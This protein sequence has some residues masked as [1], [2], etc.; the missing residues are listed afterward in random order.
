MTVKDN[1]LAIIVKCWPRLSETFV[2]QELAALQD[3]GIRYDIWSLRHPTNDKKHPLHEKVS[4]RI[5]YLPEYLHHEPLRVIRSWLS[6]RKQPGYLDARSVWWNDLKRD[7]TRNRIRRFGQALVMAAESG[8]ETRALYSHFLHTPSSV[9][10]YCAIIRDIDWGFSAHAKDIWTSPDWEIREKLDPDQYGATFGVTCTA[11]GMQQLQKLARSPDKINLAYH[12]LDL[13]RFPSP[14]NRETKSSEQTIEL[15]SVGRL[16]EKKGFDCLLRA[17]ALLPDNLQWRWTHIGGG[18]LQDSL[19]LLA[20]ELAIDKHIDWLG[21]CEQPEVIQNMRKADIFILPSRIAADG[22]RDGLP[23]VL[24]EAAS[25]KLPLVTTSISSIPEFI[26]QGV[27]GLLADDDTPETLAGLI[28]N[29]V[30]DADLRTRMAD[31][32][33]DRLIKEFDSDRGMDCVEHHLKH[34]LENQAS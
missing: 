27:H 8:Q 31:A 25:Q 24:M 7:F 13:S 10:R 32:A 20:Q 14:P 4:A 17:L 33:Y 23:N 9:T 5:H 22:D 2:A 11:V 21:E 29:L 16:V 3:R 15:L 18:A 34:M 19:Q 26:D 12:G 6:V 28:Q 30:N 1:S